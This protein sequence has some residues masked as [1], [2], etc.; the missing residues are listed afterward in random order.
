MYNKLSGYEVSEST[1]YILYFYLHTISM[2][3]FTW[4]WYIISVSLNIVLQLAAEF[5]WQLLQR[6]LNRV[7]A[8]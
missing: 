2:G 8:E 3:M 7:I 5:S 6:I 1:V 4:V